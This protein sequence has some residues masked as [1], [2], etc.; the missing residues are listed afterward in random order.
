MPYLLNRFE[1][2]GQPD[3]LA[4]ATREHVTLTLPEEVGRTATFYPDVS[5]VVEQDAD[6]RACLKIETDNLPGEMGIRIL[7]GL[8]VTHEIWTV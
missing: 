2:V 7:D 3:E 4:R 5:I 1:Y 8:G 6:G